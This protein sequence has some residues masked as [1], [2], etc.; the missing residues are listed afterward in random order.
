MCCNCNQ[1]GK[2]TDYPEYS[3]SIQVY[4]SHQPKPQKKMS[5]N[6]PMNMMGKPEVKKEERVVR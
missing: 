5:V 1:L 6:T 4:G 3:T 2:G